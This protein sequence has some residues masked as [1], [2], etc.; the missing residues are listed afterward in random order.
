M[1]SNRGS[2]W[3]LVLWQWRLVSYFLFGSFI[4]W[5]THHMAWTN[6]TLSSLPLAVIGGALGILVCL[7]FALISEAGRVLEDPFMMFWNGLPLSA[8][9]RMIEV[10]LRQRLGDQDLPPMI[11]VDEKGIL[12]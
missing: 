7:S 9:S 3:R 12:M 4:A 11:Q 10:N 6:V 2:V 5:I 1:V 8:I